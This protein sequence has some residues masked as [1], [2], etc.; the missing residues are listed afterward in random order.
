M[1]MDWVDDK[2]VKFSSVSCDAKGDHDNDDNAGSS[3]R[4]FAS[5]NS[6][7]STKDPEDEEMPKR[8]REIKR[9]RKN[10]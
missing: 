10:N 3:K 9:V 4:L 8:L 6:K 2:D 7:R 1:E 5:A